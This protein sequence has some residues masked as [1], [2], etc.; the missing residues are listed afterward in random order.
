MTKP[1][2]ILNGPN[3]NL[4][5]ER[6][7]GVYGFATL[8]GIQAQIEAE[9]AETGIAIDFRQTNHEGV[10]IDWMQEARREASG[11]IINAAAYTHTSV[12]LQDA[13]RAS[14]VP[15]IEVHLSNVFAR[16]DFRHRS[17][18]S[19]FAKGIICGF[20]AQGYSLALIA[21]RE[22]IR[23]NAA[24]PQQQLKHD[25]AADDEQA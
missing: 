17:Y 20:G 1:I 22:I 15:V 5:G 11:V 2:F 8:A 18:I 9:A 12:A 21:L 6:E 16:E 19:P 14:V 3:L 13:V 23:Q 25:S 10:L 4:L 24:S 7:P